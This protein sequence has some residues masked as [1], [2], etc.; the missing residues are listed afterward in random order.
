MVEVVTSTA[1]GFSVALVAQLILFPIY[2]I[3]V[4]M[5]TQVELVWWFTG[6]SIL[7]GYLVRR[8][9]VWFHKRR[10]NRGLE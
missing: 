8:G 1:V 10:A 5:H 6:I 4:S 2:G 9:F 7:R 3:Q